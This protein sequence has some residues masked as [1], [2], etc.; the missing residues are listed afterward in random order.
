MPIGIHGCDLMETR[1]YKVY[2]L[3]E[4]NEAA[5]KNALTLVR[6]NIFSDSFWS[7]HVIEDAKQ[8]AKVLG[9][10]IENIYWSGFWSQGDGAMF[11][12][13][14]AYVKGSVNGIKEHAPQDQELHRIAEALR[15]IQK[16]FFYSLNAKVKHSGHYYHEHCTEWTIEDKDGM[17]VRSEADEIIEPLKDFMKWIYK[18]LEEAYEFYASEEQLVEHI[19]ANEY[20]FTEDGKLD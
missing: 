19:E 18:Q 20:K 4:L 14:Y 1:T 6:Q 3:N 17:Y 16:P 2:D 5:K 9:I 8:C 12:G 10:D 11:E 7:E 15:D 13:Y